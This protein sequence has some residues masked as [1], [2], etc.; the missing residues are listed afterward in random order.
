MSKLPLDE[1][2]LMLG[3]QLWLKESIFE[4]IETLLGGVSNSSSK[5]TT[6]SSSS[7][8]M[9]V[10][11]QLEG[12]T[13]RRAKVSKIDESKADPSLKEDLFKIRENFNKKLNDLNKKGSEE[14]AK[15]VDLR[16]W[17][18]MINDSSSRRDNKENAL[19]EKLKRYKNSG[20]IK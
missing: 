8:L 7:D 6:S 10:T 20:H 9:K 18:M 2:R 12:K 5:T 17:S 14:E 19:T 1:Y 16:N 4:F 15:P 3:T 11:E 13:R